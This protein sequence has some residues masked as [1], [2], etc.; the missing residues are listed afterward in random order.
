[1]RLVGFDTP[2]T[3][4]DTAR[5]DAERERGRLAARRLAEILDSGTLDIRYR[6]HSDRYGRKLARLTVNGKNVGT[7]LIRERLAVRYQ[8]SGP[9]MDWCPRHRR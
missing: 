2:E 4:D 1:M 8:G 3:G 7:P 5:C 9:R 6:K